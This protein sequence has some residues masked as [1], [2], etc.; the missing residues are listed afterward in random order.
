MV[1]NTKEKG[2]IERASR[3]VGRASCVGQGLATTQMRLV[4]ASLVQKFRIRFL[5]GEDGKEVVRDMKDQLTAQPGRLT[6]M[7]EARV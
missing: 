4:L 3:S 2:L 5:P 7:F 6:L 1:C